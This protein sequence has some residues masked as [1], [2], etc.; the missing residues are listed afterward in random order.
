MMEIYNTAVFNN[1]GD[2]ILN[3]SRNAIHLYQSGSFYNTGHMLISGANYSG[4]AI[5]YWNANNNGR[6]INSGTVDV[7]AKALATSGVDASTNHAYFWNQNSGIVNFD[8][9]SGV[10]VKF[11]HSNYVAQND[12]TMNISGNNAIAMEGN[13]NAQLINNGTINLGA[14]GTT[15]T[16]MIGMQLDSSATADAVIVNNGTVTIADGVTG[17]GLIKQ[18]NSVNIEGVNGNNGNNSEVH[19]ANYTLPDVPGSSV[20]VSTDNVSD[21][22]GQNNL[23]GYVVGT[24]SDGSAGKLKVSNASLKGV[25][26]NTGFTSGTSATSVT[27]DNVVQGNNLTDADTITSTSVVWSAQG[28]TDANGNVDVTMTK[29]AYTDV[30]TDSSVNNVAQVLDTGYTNNDLYTSLN[31]GTTAELNSALKQIS[32]SQATTVFNEARVLS[33]RFSMLSDA[34]PE[35]AN[36]LAFNVVA[37]GD[38]RAELGNDTQYDMMALRK[39]LTL[40]EHQNLSLEY[41]IARLEG[42]GSDTAGDNGVTGGYSQLFGLKHQMAFDNGMNWNNALRYDVHQLD[43]SRSIAYGDVNKTADANVKQQYRSS[44]VKEQKPLSCVKG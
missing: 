2:F 15:D 40:T 5:N 20:F 37:K 4:N 9:D 21:N 41:G 32:G 24:S 38:P 39:S 17:S 42:N 13:K 36:G 27:F 7:T 43:S 14:Q 18:G 44:V 10:A 30:V 8:K 3:N 25:S 34:A 26:V 22:G 11:T 35:V 1:S 29:N 31:V 19:Y 16:G 33:N 28:N 6:F 23:N 12:G